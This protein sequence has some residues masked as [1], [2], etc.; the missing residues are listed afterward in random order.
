MSRTKQIILS[1]KN[2]NKEY[3]LVQLVNKSKKRDLNCPNCG[4][5]IGRRN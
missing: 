4:K 3:D 2:C 5:Y 1:C